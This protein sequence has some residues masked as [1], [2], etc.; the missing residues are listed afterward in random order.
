MNIY[1]YFWTANGQTK[2]SGPNI[3]KYSPST[4]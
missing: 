3:I 4:V 2:D 1:I